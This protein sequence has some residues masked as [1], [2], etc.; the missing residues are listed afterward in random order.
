[1]GKP[2][3]KDKSLGI[4]PAISFYE[5]EDGDTTEEGEEVENSYH[6]RLNH[7]G[8]LSKDLYNPLNIGIHI[9]L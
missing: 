4:E 2:L 7:S 5:I 6:L 9:W 8:K 1:M 3:P